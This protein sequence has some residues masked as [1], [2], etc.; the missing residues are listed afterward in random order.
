MMALYAHLSL[1]AAATLS[2]LS[3][4]AVAR[5][6]RKKKW[7]VKVHKALNGASLGLALAGFAV[8]FSMVQSSGGPHFRVFH[9]VVGLAVLVLAL[10]VPILGFG[11]FKAKDKKR[12]P[13][14]KLAHRWLGRITALGMSGAVLLGLSLI[15]VI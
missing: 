8:A 2:M 7:W 10:L 9:G 13:S 12:V 15:G 11:I 5:Y 3:A 1:M 4:I 14:L 6:F